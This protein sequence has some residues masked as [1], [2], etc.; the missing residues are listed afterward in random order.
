MKDEINTEVFEQAG[1]SSKEIIAEIDNAI[2]IAEKVNAKVDKVNEEYF[3]ALTK[4][5][6]KTAKKLYE[7]SRE[8]NSGLLAAFKYAEDQFVRLTW[9]D[10]PIFPH[11]HAQNNI[12]NLALSID[13]LDKGDLTTAVDEYLWA[14]DNNWYAYDFD[15]EVF[16]YFTDYVLEAP[17]EKLMWGAGR[18]VGHEDLFDTINALVEKNEQANPDV[19]A[20]LETLNE[21]LE[22]QKELLKT[23]VADETSS[24]KELGEMLDE[25]K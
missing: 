20:E 2:A 8:L 16:D 15:K 18:I 24:V 21:A 1:V 9:E 23:T 11:E 6:A 12:N 13:A 25:L 10:E 19:S 4:G 3:V 7:E 22:R 14:I 5:D 17:K